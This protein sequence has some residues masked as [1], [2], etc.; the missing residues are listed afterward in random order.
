MSLKV[1]SQ[2]ACDSRKVKPGDIFFALT[3]VRTDGHCHLFDAFERGAKGAVVAASYKGPRPD[4]DLFVVDDPL[5]TLQ[6]L[7]RERIASLGAEVVGITGSLGKTTI[8]QFAQELLATKYRTCATLGNQNSQVGLPLSILQAPGKPQVMVLE[9]GMTGEGQIAKLVQ[10]APPTVALISTIDLV[11]AEFFEGLEAI[12]RAKAEIFSHP[13]TR[14]ALLPESL[15]LPCTL[16]KRTFSITSPE[17]HFY[18]EQRGETLYLFEGGIEQARVSWHLHGKHNLHNYLA[19]IALARSMRVSWE[20][21]EEATPRLSLPS[22]RFEVVVRRNITLINDAYNSAA[23][24]VCAALESL[25]KVEGKRIGV[26]SE[27]RELGKFSLECHERIAEEALKYL[28]H[29]IC[30]GQGCLPIKEKWEKMGRPIDWFEER[31]QVLEHLRKV[32][33]GGDLI[34][35]KGARPYALEELWEAF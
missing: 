29:L 5:A 12:G 23:S 6:Q 16:P 3:G 18:L 34:L 10:I 9:M 32:A 21:I 35:F 8:K 2:V 14:L 11:H 7:A 13:K 17:A 24:S 27:M 28:D 15:S 30:I 31:T 26:L 20:Q 4:F 22:K 19:A 25:P 33:R 1:D